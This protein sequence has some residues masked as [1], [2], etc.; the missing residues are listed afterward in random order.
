MQD[1]P[2]RCPARSELVL[3]QHAPSEVE[4]LRFREMNVPRLIGLG[5]N[6]FPADRKTFTVA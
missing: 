2:Q 1:D 5:W 4:R 6:T 3:C